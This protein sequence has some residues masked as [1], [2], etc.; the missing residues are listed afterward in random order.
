MV[1]AADDVGDAHVMVVDDD[2]EHVGRRSVG[3]QQDEVVELLVGEGH[4]AL[5]A[6][7]DHR[8]AVGRSLEADRRLDAGRGLGR[9]AVAPAPV[10]AR[11]QVVGA[12]LLAHRGELFLGGVAAIGKAGGD[13]LFRRLPV[14]GGAAE[15]RDR[16]AFPVEAEPGQAVKNGGDRSVGRTLAIRV[17]DAQQHLAAEAPGIEPVEERSA[18]AADMQEAGR[19]GSE[20]RDDGCGHREAS[21]SIDRMTRRP[22]VS[23]SERKPFRVLRECR[24]QCNAAVPARLASV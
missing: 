12:L 18:R 1:V 4:A 2:G 15:L 8:L 9:V 6:V 24:L 17:L 19:R 3:A 16:L 22:A 20:T 13:K 23:L 5:D 7:L 21:W 11:G 10:I 14:A